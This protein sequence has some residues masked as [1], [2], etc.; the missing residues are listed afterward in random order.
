MAAADPS[1]YVSVTASCAACNGPMPTG[2]TR[3]Y[4]SPA[5][6]QDGY[7]RRHQ[8]PTPA[9]VLPAR[10][11]R[12]EGT[13][14]GCNDCDSRYLGEQWCFD[15]SRPCRRLGPGG[16]CPCCEEIILFED[17]LGGQIDDTTPKN[18]PT[19]TC[20]STMTKSP[21]SQGKLNGLLIGRDSA[22][23]VRQRPSGVGDDERVA[24][25][26]LGFARVQV[27]QPAHRQP[28]KV[29][30]V[31]AHAAGDRDCQRPDRGELIDD[32]Q[33]RPVRLQLGE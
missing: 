19:T 1:R 9:I 30:D 26:G 8:L 4:C 14:Y 17:I 28:G 32:C 3:Q 6:R 13:V 12:R 2:R 15:C 23:C 31:D 21:R 29:A 27:R 10:R 7:R 25:V 22:Q 18:L 5:C 33:D 16:P 20:P 24:R 11:S